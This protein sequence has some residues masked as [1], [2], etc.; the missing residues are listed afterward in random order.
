MSNGIMTIN[1]GTLPLALFGREG[2][3]RLPGWLAVPVWLAR[4]KAATLS[5]PLVARLPALDVFLLYGTGR[6]R[7]CC[8]CCRCGC[9]P[10]ESGRGSKKMIGAAGENLTVGACWS[11]ARRR[12]PGCGFGPGCVK[13]SDRRL[14]G[15]WRRVTTRGGGRHR[16]GIWRVR[17]CQVTVPA[18]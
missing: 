16:C 12:D 9:L 15:L 8:S 11:P 14:A 18:H 4:A 13:T 2:Y 1:R 3:A 7:P 5:A 17:D 6:R 10:V